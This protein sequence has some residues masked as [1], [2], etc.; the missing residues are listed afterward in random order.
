MDGGDVPGRAVERRR[1]GGEH[2]RE[3]P[4][5]HW[6]GSRLDRSSVRPAGPSAGAGACRWAGGPHGRPV[7]P[8]AGPVT[9]RQLAG[10]LAP[11]TTPFD[12]ATG[13][14]APVHLRHNVSRLIAAGLD[15]VVVAGSTGESPL[16]DADEQRRMVAWV[17]EVLPDKSWL[18]VGTGAES[19]RQAVALTRAAAAE[20]AD[21]VL[22]RPP[23][24]FS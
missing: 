14:V 24:Y 7:E 22:A 16:L 2:P 3:L 8:A 12:S 1:D 15:G 11:I 21:A 5:G 13:D 9:E 20:G 18:V 4:L 23:G 17:R 10:V 6:P 19:T